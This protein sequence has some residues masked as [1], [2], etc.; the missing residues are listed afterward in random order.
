VM[1]APTALI[2]P[3][4]DGEDSSYFEWLGAGALELHAVA[5]AMHQIDRQAALSQVRFGFDDSSLYVRVDGVRPV[6][7]YLAEGGS[8]VVNFLRPAGRR[9]TCAGRQGGGTEAL[10]S[11]R[12][13]DT[14]RAVPEASLHAEAGSILELQIPLATFGPL[15]PGEVTFFVALHD[16]NDVEVERHPAGRPVELAVPDE[17]FAARNWTA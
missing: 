1:T 15:G 10:L 16:A 17:R 7:A 4:I 12:E 8:V 13:G 11:V 9:V 2:S 14:W 6:H 3:V 5:G